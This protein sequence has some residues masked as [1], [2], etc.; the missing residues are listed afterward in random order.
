MNPIY[1]NDLNSIKSIKL[2]I[3]ALFSKSI[4]LNSTIITDK[5][6]INADIFLL[7]LYKNNYLKYIPIY[8]QIVIN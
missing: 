5:E 2:L 4:K 6:R 1:P 7:N 3:I 8:T